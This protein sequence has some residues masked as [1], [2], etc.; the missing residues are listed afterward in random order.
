[1]HSL[2]PI[3]AGLALCTG[4]IAYSAYEFYV[5]V[6]GVAQD[7]PAGPVYLLVEGRDAD[8]DG[9]SDQG[10]L[11]LAC[12]QRALRSASLRWNVK[13]PRDA[14]SGQA[15]GK[16][17]AGPV[18]KHLGQ[19]KIEDFVAASIDLPKITPKIA[20]EQHGRAAGSSGWEPIAF[21]DPDA[22][23]AA[24]AEAAA[25]VKKSKSNISTN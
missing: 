6:K 9:V 7:S 21:A 20:K 8:G 11:R 14:A 23:C 18:T 15:S 16:Q 22:A 17:S 4:S 13:S 1:M 5:K 2:R 19:P 12:A 25:T 24:A 3:I 10:I